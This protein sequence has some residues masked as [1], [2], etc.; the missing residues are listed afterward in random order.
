MI[1]RSLTGTGV[2]L[3]AVAASGVSAQTRVTGV[4]PTSVRLQA[5]GVSVPVTIDGQQLAGETFSA[6][7]R[8]TG[9]FVPGPHLLECT[10]AM[11]YTAETYTNNIAR[12]LTL[13][14]R[15]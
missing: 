3:L 13:T 15:Q 9:T 1:A 5:G 6:Q 10:I 12:S 8:P 2:A 4:S 7:V 11:P 14:V